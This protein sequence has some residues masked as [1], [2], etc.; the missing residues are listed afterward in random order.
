MELLK[1][2]IV[3]LRRGNKWAWC[4]WHVKTFTDFGEMQWFPWN[5]YRVIAGSKG[6]CNV[7]VRREGD[8]RVLR[9]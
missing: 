3:K 8:R 9:C 7:F 6:T 2:E 1:K 5:S 4:V